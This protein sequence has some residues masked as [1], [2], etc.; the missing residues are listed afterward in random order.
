[1]SRG[2]SPTWISLAMRK[3]GANELKKRPRAN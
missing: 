3:D 2:S 1:M